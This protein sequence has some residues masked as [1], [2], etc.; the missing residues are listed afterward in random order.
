MAD[1]NDYIKDTVHPLENTNEQTMAEA[2]YDRNFARLLH[3]SI[4]L[5]TEQAELQDAIKKYLMYGKTIDTV[6]IIEELGDIMW[7]VGLAMDSLGTTLEEVL[8]KNSSKLKARYGDRFT[9]QAALDRNL[10]LEREKL[11]G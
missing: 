8:A 2:F 4:G 10:A 7:Y 3:A 5:N 11:E 6:N 9:H 1:F